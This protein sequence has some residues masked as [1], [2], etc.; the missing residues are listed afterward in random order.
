MFVV[1]WK[2]EGAFPS[3]LIDGL[4]EKP[5]CVHVMLGQK[6]PPSG[7]LVLKPGI[8]RN[9][10]TFGFIASPILFD[11]VCQG[12]FPNLRLTGDK[13]Y[14]DLRI[15]IQ[16][17]YDSSLHLLISFGDEE[18]RLV[19]V[20]KSKVRGDVILPILPAQTSPQENRTHAVTLGRHNIRGAVSDKPRRLHAYG[21]FLNGLIKQL[22]FGLSAITAKFQ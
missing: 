15:T 10:V 14:L 17:G 4:Q 2:V 5:K 7:M 21:K 11:Y 19:E 1:K 9:H 8:G 20:F 6:I 12:A 18:S 3:S 22:G 16:K 13:Q